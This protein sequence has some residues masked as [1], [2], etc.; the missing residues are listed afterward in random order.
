[1]L[2]AW[3]ILSAYLE[4][5][6]PAVHHIGGDTRTDTRDA[7]DRGVRYAARGPTVRDGTPGHVARVTATPRRL[8]TGNTTPS[9]TSTTTGVCRRRR[10]PRGSHHRGHTAPSRGRRLL[11]VDSDPGRCSNRV[12]RREKTQSKC[13]AVLFNRVSLPTGYASRSSSKRKNHRK[14]RR[15][16][17]K[18]ASV[19]KISDLVQSHANT[20]HDLF[21][22]CTNQIQSLV[23]NSLSV[24]R[25]L[26]YV[27]L[28]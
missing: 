4:R 15:L 18:Y 16:T 17:E 1:M 10:R 26:V 22:H 27:P 19:S 23:I 3:N 13:P 2:L 8:T 14:P 12:S 6:G 7:R 28:F 25:L 5:T 9:I 20:D 21:I 11:L 24:I